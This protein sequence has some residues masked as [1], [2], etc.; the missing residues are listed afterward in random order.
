M[1]AILE[2]NAPEKYSL[3]ARACLGILTRAERRGKAL[4]PI[5]WD[6]LMEVVDS[7]S[8]TGR[9]AQEGAKE[10]SQPISPELS[11]QEP[12]TMSAYQNTGRSWWN[13]DDVAET[14]RTPCGGDAMKANAVCVQGNAVDRDTRMNGSGVSDDGVS[15]TLNQVDRHAACYGVDCRNATLDEEKTH[16]IQAHNPYGTSL[17]CTPSVIYDARGNGAKR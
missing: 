11:P 14:I 6:A 13:G 7:A 8:S 5:L 1:S 16:T 17:N 15:P 4:P 10:S 2:E 3:S 12:T 9:A